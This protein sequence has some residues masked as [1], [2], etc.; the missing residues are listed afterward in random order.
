[1]PAVFDAAARKSARVTLSRTGME[2][3]ASIATMAMAMATS[4]RVKPRDCMSFLVA[5]VVAT[6]VDAVWAVAHDVERVAVARAGGNVHVLLVPGVVRHFFEK[7]L[8]AAGRIGQRRQTFAGVWV[9]V[10]RQLIQL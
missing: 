3:P 10:L 1:M 2:M 6:A 5:D 4:T 8:V 7:R 9:T